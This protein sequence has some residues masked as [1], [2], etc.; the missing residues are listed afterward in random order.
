MGPVSAGNK[1]LHHDANLFKDRLLCQDDS[2][3]D[4]LESFN[5]CTIVINA[6][7]TEAKTCVCVWEFISYAHAF[8]SVLTF[9]HRE[10]ARKTN[11]HLRPA[12]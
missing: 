4:V 6:E 3:K 1:K 8:V 10:V 5:E 7:V 12:D 2:A 9:S 11:T